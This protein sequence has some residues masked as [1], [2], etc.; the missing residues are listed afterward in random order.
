MA[1]KRLTRSSKKKNQSKKKKLDQ[2]RDESESSID[3]STTSESEDEIEKTLQVQ[4]SNSTNPLTRGD[5]EFY[6][7]KVRIFWITI[8]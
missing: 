4:K 3:Y 6:Y 7:S 2:M 8:Y 5:N 1:G